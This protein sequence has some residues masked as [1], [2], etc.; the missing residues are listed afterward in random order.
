[1][2]IINEPR[3]EFQ[4]WYS[5]WSSY[6]Y[7]C[8]LLVFDL[9]NDSP[10][11][12]LEILCKWIYNLGKTRGVVKCCNIMDHDRRQRSCNA[13]NRCACIGRNDNY[14][15]IWHI[16]E[17]NSYFKYKLILILMMQFLYLEVSL[18][19]LVRVDSHIMIYFWLIL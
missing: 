15:R 13:N 4:T 1:M 16:E 10:N 6:R 17:Y 2:A 9:G 5:L 12:Y 19:N 18:L 7:E 14:R 11:N 8:M 3:K